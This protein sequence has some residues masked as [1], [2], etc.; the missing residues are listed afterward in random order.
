MNWRILLQLFFLSI[1]L[2]QILYLSYYLPQIAFSA[3]DFPQDIK[4]SLLLAGV[5]IGMLWAIKPRPPK[6][7]PPVEEEKDPTKL[8][9][10][11]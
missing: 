8:E 1:F 5:A 3:D 11:R 9:E 6:E 4:L 7:A 2:G 10:K